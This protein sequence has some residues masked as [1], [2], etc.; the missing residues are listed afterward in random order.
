MDTHTYNTFVVQETITHKG[1]NLIR[2]L[3]AYLNTKTLEKGSV[4]RPKNIQ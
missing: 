1:K 3:Y 2:Y 4:V